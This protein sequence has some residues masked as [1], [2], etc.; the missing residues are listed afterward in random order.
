MSLYIERTYVPFGNFFF[1]KIYFD[2][3]F[4]LPIQCATID[5]EFCKELGKK[6]SEHRMNTGVQSFFEMHRSVVFFTHF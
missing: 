5:P 3:I 2:K 1:T 4:T 6:S